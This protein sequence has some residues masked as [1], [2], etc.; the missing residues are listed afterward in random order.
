MVFTFYSTQLKM[1]IK[2]KIIPNLLFPR[3]K[4]GK[5]YLFLIQFILPFLVLN[6]VK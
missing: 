3:L 1:I 6:L 2:E 5:E 4:E